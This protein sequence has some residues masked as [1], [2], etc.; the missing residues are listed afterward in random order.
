MRVRLEV[1]LPSA[2]VG[3]VRVALGR[4]EVGVPEHLLHRTKVG[5]AFEEMGRE[6]VTEQVWVH[7]SRLEAG[8]IGELPQDE[9]RTG[10]RQGAAAGVQEEVGSVAPVE[11]RPAE[12]EVAADGLGRRS[13]EGNETLLAAL[14]QHA[15]D[16]LLDRDAALLEPGG[17][18]DAQ[19]CAVQ[20]LHERAVAQR[21]RRR[22]DGGVD[23]ALGLR[24]R[25]RAR[26][27]AC[28][29]R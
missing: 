2:P 24:R 12:C 1:D 26:Q 11:M 15:D 7:A 25:E 13:A 8:P 28:P 29:S 23:Q 20:E 19:A 6:G 16:A 10:A 9:E 21:A 3:D 4:P 18:G 27:R 22:P 17:L 5:S 14:S